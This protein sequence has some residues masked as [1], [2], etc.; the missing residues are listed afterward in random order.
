VHYRDAGV[1]TANEIRIPVG[2][3]VALT[4]TSP[5]VIHS[6]WVP[7]LAGK[8][9]LIPGRSN[10]LVLQADRAG[11]FRGACAEFCGASHAQM[12][13][14]VVAQP[15]ADFDDWRRRQQAPAQAGPGTRAGRAAFLRNGCG[16]CHRVRG[17]P[18]SGTVGPDLTHDGSRLELAA[19]ALANDRDALRAWIADPHAHKPGALMPAF[20]VL[21]DRDLDAVAAWLAELQ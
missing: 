11:V 13:L 1:D 16:G 15:P 12:R 18:A 21:D 9:D 10:T 3:P 7:A 20:A 17:T 2:R 19:G 6:F 5:D 4:L 8:M 14:L